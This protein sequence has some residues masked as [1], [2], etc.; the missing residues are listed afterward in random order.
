MLAMNPI[1]LLTDFK[2]RCANRQELA[3][4][5]HFAGLNAPLH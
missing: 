5:K 1:E 4:L 3:T 2:F